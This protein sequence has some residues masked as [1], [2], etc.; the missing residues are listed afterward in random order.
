[1]PA[2]TDTALSVLGGTK[3]PP[4]EPESNRARQDFAMPS[5]PLIPAPSPSFPR[6]REPRACPWPE[7]GPPA[8]SRSP[9]I[10]ACAGATANQPTIATAPPVIPAQAGIQ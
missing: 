2:E 8:F 9:W 4:D 6:K 3:T 1:M 10:P 7:Q 5:T